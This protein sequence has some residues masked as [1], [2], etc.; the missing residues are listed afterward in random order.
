[1]FGEDRGFKDL[2][3]IATSDVQ[4]RY[5]VQK[6]RV[7]DSA[8]GY[9]IIVR[10]FFTWAVGKKMLRTSPAAG[11]NMGNANSQAR[12]KFCTFAQRDKCFKKFHSRPA[13]YAGLASSGILFFVGIYLSGPT[14]T[15]RTKEACPQAPLGGL[16]GT[17]TNLICHTKPKL[18]EQSD[19][20]PPPR[21]SRR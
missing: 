8:H 6:K 21:S 13:R 14:F 2:P 20:N 7:P 17:K 4:S 5:D 9:M 18:N 12:V 1:M 3:G 16:G 19:H 15:R 10:A 11:V